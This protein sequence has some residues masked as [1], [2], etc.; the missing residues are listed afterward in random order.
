VRA[1]AL[2][3]HAGESDYAGTYRHV[4]TYDCATQHIRDKYSS[5]VEIVVDSQIPGTCHICIF[6]YRSS[7]NGLFSRRNF[8]KEIRAMGNKIDRKRSIYKNGTSVYDELRQLPSL[9][10]AET[11]M[12]NRP[13]IL[14][15][16]Q[17]SR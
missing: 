7:A 11:L 14:G 1:P 5:V 12:S 17:L 9:I 16:S 13:E 3:A 8:S 4:K 15:R 6:E 10:M 2:V